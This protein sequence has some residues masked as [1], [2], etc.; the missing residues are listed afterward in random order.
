MIL[1]CLI[2]SRFFQKNLFLY[3]KNLKLRVDEIDY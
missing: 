2:I 1:K 3:L